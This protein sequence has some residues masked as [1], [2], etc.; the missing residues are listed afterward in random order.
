MDGKRN[1]KKP[2][3]YIAALILALAFLFART[4]VYRL[5][6][7]GEESGGLFFYCGAGLRPVAEEIVREF[8]AKTGIRVRTDFNAS[9][10]LLG[11]I[12]VSGEGDLFMP[13]DEY[14]TRKAREQGLARTSRP[15]AAFVP[16]IMVGEGNPRGIESVEDLAGEGLNLGLAD[17]RTA[18][19]GRLAR[20]IFE[21]NSVPPGKIEENLVYDSVTVHD[22]ATSVELGHIDAAVVWEPVALRYE[23]ADIVHI[24][25]E[26]NIISPIP[27]AVLSCSENVPAAEKFMDFVLSERGREIF[28]KHN[29]GEIK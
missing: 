18:A 20:M 10:L 8:T 4:G 16:V 13:G 7:G 2:V 24:P 11:K 14:Y 9:N 5:D 19:I 17:E 29:Y 26:K 22:L 28:R 12:Q 15:V 23:N 25:E 21:K 1:R 6:S 27:L 3:Y